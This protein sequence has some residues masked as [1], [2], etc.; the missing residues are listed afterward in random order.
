MKPKIIARTLEF[1][2]RPKR[3]NMHTGNV[4]FSTEEISEVGPNDTVIVNVFDPY[5]K[6]ITTQKYTSEEFHRKLK[7]RTKVADYG[8]YRITFFT[9]PYGQAH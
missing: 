1:N 7:M 4:S 9:L 8:R 2:K 3:K 5:G 6:F